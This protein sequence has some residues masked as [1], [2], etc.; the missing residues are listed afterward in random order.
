MVYAN[1]SVLITQAEQLKGQGCS[2]SEIARRLGVS[3][4][5]TVSYWLNP[6]ARAKIKAYQRGNR[7]KRSLWE[8][9]YHEKNQ[10]VIC[11]RARQW[12]EGNKERAKETRK[13]YREGHKGEMQA[14]LKAYHDLHRDELLEKGKAYREV[15]K[16]EI[17]E[18]KRLYR[19]ANGVR[20]AEK[21]KAY[22]EANREAICE[23]SRSWYVNNREKAFENSRRRRAK[24]SSGDKIRQEEYEALFENQKGLCAYCG[25]VMLTEGNPHHPDYCNID[26]I[27]PISRGGKHEIA[28]IVFACRECNS[29]KRAKTLKKWRPELIS[30]IN[31]LLALRNTEA[32][33]VY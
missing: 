19:E 29:S 3:S 9:E 18:K 31:G 2:Y 25:K 20:I 13:K 24:V 11:D 28:N 15:N 32:V 4:H 1:R 33:G 6:A 23:R 5:K 7:D 27:Y 12:Y 10:E 22:H 17:R 21:K 16:D 8:K 26:H 30:R 14:Y